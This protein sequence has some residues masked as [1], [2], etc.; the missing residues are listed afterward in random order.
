MIIRLF[1][2]ENKIKLWTLCFTRRPPCLSVSHQS[3]LVCLSSGV[4]GWWSPSLWPRCCP[5]ACWF[6]SCRPVAARWRFTSPNVETTH[7]SRWTTSTEPL[8]EP[9]EAPGNQGKG[10]SHWTTRTLRMKSG[11][12]RGGRSCQEDQ[13]RRVRTLCH[14]TKRSSWV[15]MDRLSETV[16]LILIFTH[17]HRP[18]CWSSKTRHNRFYSAFVYRSRKEIQ[19]RGQSFNLDLNVLIPNSRYGV[20]NISELN[21]GSSSILR[22]VSP[23]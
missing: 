16:Y 12:R 22:L 13:R 18:S 21:S 3:P 14:C 2:N 1:D 7:T 19:K 23:R 10:L 9:E 17:F 15:L 6:T 11:R 5:S 8:H 4:P 20:L